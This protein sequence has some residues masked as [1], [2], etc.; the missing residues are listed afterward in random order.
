M[1]RLPLL[2]AMIVLLA[3]PAAASASPERI[4]ADCED[5][6]RLDGRYSASDLN[7]AKRDIPEDLDEY[8]NCVEL[9]NGALSRGSRAGGG[10]A[11]GGGTVPFGPGGG[12]TGLPP[13][14]GVGS[15]PLGPDGKPLDPLIDATPEERRE[16]LAASSGRDI[17]PT[18]TGVRPGDPDGDLPAPLVAVLILAG[19]ATLTGMGLA[20]KQLVVG[21]PAF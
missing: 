3:S 4:Y 18:A 8:S 2:I 1:Y 15:L 20:I 7:E 6:G 16:V 14:N 19:L 11:A 17:R 5:N 10:G 13:G 21:R 9:I 12:P